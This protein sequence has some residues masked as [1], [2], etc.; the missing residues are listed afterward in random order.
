MAEPP[1]VAHF[2]TA[3]LPLLPQR[4]VA[5]QNYTE[6]ALYDH[7]TITRPIIQQALMVMDAFAACD[8]T[9][10]L[11]HKHIVCHQ[12]C[13]NHYNQQLRDVQGKLDVGVALCSVSPLKVLVPQTLENFRHTQTVRHPPAQYPLIHVLPRLTPQRSLP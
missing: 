10:V 8:G 2:F 12:L 3:F 6:Q 5:P 9:V 13:R 11:G 1:P 4:Q 7:K